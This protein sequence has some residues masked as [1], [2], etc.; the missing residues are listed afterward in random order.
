MNKDIKLL[1]E[2]LAAELGDLHGHPWFQWAWAPDCYY[3]VRRAKAHYE[4][5]TR[6]SWADRIGKVWVMAEWGPPPMSREAWWHSVSGQFPYPEKG[7]EVVHAETALAPG[8]MPDA[9]LTQFYIHRIN[10]QASKSYARTLSE[11]T[12]G[13]D[14]DQLATR[15]EFLDYADEWFPAFW[16]NGQAH[17]PGTRGAHVSFGGLADTGHASRSYVRSEGRWPQVR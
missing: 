3:Y 16:K 9:E 14:Q 12:A 7:R 11:I 13:L 8:V 17:E 2:R 6:Y 5:Y 4:S 15:K 1:N 10:E